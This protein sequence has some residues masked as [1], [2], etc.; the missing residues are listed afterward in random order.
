MTK[1]LTSGTS[2]TYRFLVGTSSA[3]A[4]APPGNHPRRGRPMLRRVGQEALVITLAMLAY[5]LARLITAGEVEQAMD[6]AAR[7]L[8]MEHVMLLP[9]E[10]GV[11]RLLVST[12][13]LVRAANGYYAL[14]HFPATA[15]FLCWTFL[16]RPGHYAWVRNSLIGLTAVALAVH[17]FT[18]LAPPR[19]LPRL[20]FVDT[21]T[22]FG[23]A[24]YGPPTSD[25]ISNQY[26]AMPSLHVG[27]SL[28]VAVGLVVMTRSRWRWL[29]LLHPFATLVVVVGTANHY[30]LDALVAGGLLGLVLLVQGPPPPA[31]PPPER[32]GVEPGV[33]AVTIPAQRSPAGRRPRPCP[34]RSS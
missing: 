5:R 3:E 9:P 23:P 13:W 12:G 6:N 7:V 21:G 20:G 29:W 2:A 1:S 30:W 24:V 33:P 19:M 15:L 4:P 34:R 31:P 14:V 32:A 28:F 17:L 11:Q 10:L 8:R 22:V 25:H 18:P 16:R 26:A 27:W